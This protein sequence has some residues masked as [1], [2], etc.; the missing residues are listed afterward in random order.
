MVDQASLH[1]GGSGCCTNCQA[2]IESQ[3]EKPK[4][5]N[6]PKMYGKKALVIEPVMM[7]DGIQIPA[8]SDVMLYPIEGEHW[9]WRM[10]VY[11]GLQ[12]REYTVHFSWLMSEGINLA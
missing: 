11:G 5:I 7:P 8:C 6:N 4:G 1:L 3:A 2:W 12:H 10:A 9:T